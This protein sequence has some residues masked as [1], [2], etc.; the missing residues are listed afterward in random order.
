M[1]KK[2][3]IST[4]GIGSRVAGLGIVPNKSLLPINYESI[5][6]KILDKFDNDVE[7]LIAV[8][9]N[10]DIVKSFLKLAHP[11]KKFTFIKVNKYFGKGSGAGYTLNFCKKYLQCPFIYTACD[12]ITLEKP[13]F[14]KFN[15]VGVSKTKISERFLI[16]EKKSK[17]SGYSFFNKKRHFEISKKKRNFDAF[18]G[19]ANIY[20][21]K[22]FWKGFE[23]NKQLSDNELQFS[24]GLHLLSN[25]IKLKKFKWLDTGTN[26]SYIDTLNFFK[27]KT[28][29]KPGE[30]VYII[31]NRVIK[32]FSDK[33][34]CKILKE[35]A[36]SLKS[37]GPKIIKS[38]DNFL[39]YE[40][41]KGKHLTEVNEKLFSK[42]LEN[43]RKNFWKKKVINSKKFKIQCKKFYKDKTYERVSLAINQNPNIDRITSINGKKIPSIYKILRKVKWQFLSEGVPVNFHGDLQPENIIV[44]KNNDFKL[45]D[46]RTDFSELTYGDIYYEFSKLNH[47]LTINTRKVLDGK[48]KVHYKSNNEV[49]YSFEK[50]N[51]LLKFQ[52]ILYQFIEKNN[53]NLNKVK[54][55]TALIYLNI[56]KFYDNPYSE[57]LF[58]HGKKQLH[59]LTR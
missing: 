16:F 41:I 48:I 20:D 53:F 14:E 12:T 35:R 55:L 39:V 40:Y 2:L 43:L 5:I 29:R 26:E 52:K 9:H 18:I 8:G 7:V 6:T 36:K 58:Y 50:K 24:N 57:L 22:L 46:W 49:E 44:T 17:F 10:A 56:S 23:A 32:Y 13:K 15:W 45:I 4:A 27:D 30:V 51:I 59:K 1:K 3:F 37:N 47:M 25:K 28:Q 31:K 21:Y 34:K 42:F 19:L 38:S 54:I 33:K 11:E